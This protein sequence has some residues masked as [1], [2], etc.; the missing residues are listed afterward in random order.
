MLT[1][2]DESS[3]TEFSSTLQLV[4]QD[5]LNIGGTQQ[6][7]GWKNLNIQRGAHVDFVADMRDLS[8]LADQSYDVVYTSHTLEHLGYNFE[9]PKTLAGIRRILRDGGKLFV[10]V[11]DLDTLCRMF[12]NPRATSEERFHIQ[13]MMFGGQSDR[14][15]YHYVGLN[16]ELLTLYLLGAG[17]RAAVRVPEFNLFVDTSTL[18]YNGA[19]ISLNIVATR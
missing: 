13:R 12:L 2:T 5:W 9:L 3:S 14:F 11:P 15:D 17:F 1:V 16:A 6:K 8:M 7:E 10:S 18:R 19:L 4:G